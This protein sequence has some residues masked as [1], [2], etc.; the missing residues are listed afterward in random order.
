VDAWDNFLKRQEALLGSGVVDKWLRPLKVAH[1]DA[2]N[3]YLE[4]EDPFQIQWF[5]EHVRPLLKNYFLT[6]SAKPIKVH[7]T[8]SASSKPLDAKKAVVIKKVP[9]S[10]TT[11]PLDPLLTWDRFIFEESNAPL[12]AFLKELIEA[13]MPLG[14]FNPLYIWG[15]SG[16]GKTHLLTALTFLL[17]ERGLNVLFAKMETFTEHVV[18]AIRSSSMHTFRHNYRNVDVLLIDG[19]QTLSGKFATQEEFFH[20]FNTLH[21]Q[22]KQIILSSNC[23]PSEL[24]QIEQRLTS[25]F[26]W[27][28][29]L[30]LHPLS[31]TSLHTLLQ[32]KLEALSFSLPEEVQAFLLS[33]FRSSNGL[34][35]AI[36]TLLFRSHIDQIS[37][38]TLTD[39]QAL[40]APLVAKREISAEKIQAAVAAVYQVDKE[41]LTSRSQ[42]HEHVLP[43]QIAIFLCRDTLKL[44]FQAI[45][46]LF[47]RDHSTVMTSVRH[48]ESKLSQKDP[49]IV[50]AL[51][52]IRKK[53]TSIS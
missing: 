27:G 29:N 13:E 48:I 45:G 5:E 47:F 1:F 15:E 41:E 26:E 46:K 40:L 12:L 42:A 6:S 30:H 35:Q 11:D 2:A 20:T 9:P 53:L 24:E 22:K 33:S 37:T 16:S 34:Q 49:E 31:Q 52:K 19:V 21:S 43:R 18:A 39:V 4:A 8:L 50:N 14:I 51:E 7:L 28:I 36:E 17:K 25:R 44:P 10:F 38:W 3:L 32:N 23:P